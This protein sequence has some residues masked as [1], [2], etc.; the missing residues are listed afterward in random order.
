MNA[1]L[2]IIDKTL[3]WFEDVLAIDDPEEAIIEK[4]DELIYKTELIINADRGEKIP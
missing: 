2:K 1:V 3:D 4:L